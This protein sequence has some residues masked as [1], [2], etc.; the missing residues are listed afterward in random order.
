M[1]QKYNLLITEKTNNILEKEIK[2]YINDLNIQID[3]N[4]NELN[5]LH[6]DMSYLTQENKRLKFLAREIIEARNETEIFFLDALN[7][8]KKDLYKLKKEKSIR[9]C[10][11]PTLKQYYDKS[12]PKIDIREMTPEMRERILRNLFEKI[13]KGYDENHFK[14]LS[15]IM[16][17]DLP[18]NND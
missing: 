2:Q 4:Q 11:F 8:A 18:D 1:S 7:E 6:E 16:E 3:Q 17:I 15:N 12:N 10:F 5:T 13:N 14:E 9:G